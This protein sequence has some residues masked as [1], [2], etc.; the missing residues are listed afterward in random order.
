MKLC[1]DQLEMFPD[2]VSVMIGEKAL[3]EILGMS[4]ERLRQDRETGQGI[5]FITVS[6]KPKYRR[7]D[8]IAFITKS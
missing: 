3:A 6:K 5:K 7:D 4:V 2:T 8:V 1:P